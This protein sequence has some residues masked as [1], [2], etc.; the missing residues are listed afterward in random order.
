M[1]RYLFANTIGV[2]AVLL[3]M[4]WLQGGPA[5]AI[6][7]TPPADNAAPREGTGGASRSNFFVPPSD[8]TAPHRGTG[9]ASRGNFFVPPSD[10]AAPGESTGGA[11]RGGFFLPPSDNAAPGES[12]GGASRGEFFTPPSENGAPQESV[13]GGARSNSYGATHT[14]SQLTV[15]SMMAVTPE[16]FFGTTLEARPTILVYVPASNANEAIFTLKD[17]AKELVYQ[18]TLPIP[19]SGGV[20]SVEL[21]ADAPE[22]AVGQNY[23]WYLAMMLD[24]ELSPASPFV[25]GWVK[26]I[27]PSPELAAT[28]SQSEGLDDIA[29]LGAGGIWYDTVAQL[30]QLQAPQTDAAIAGHWQELLESVGLTDISTAP[31]VM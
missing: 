15:S 26:R 29:A 16:S 3:S 21:P 27:S 2:A 23:Q 7:F 25:D 10:N 20:V 14:T 22:L 17:E 13:G 8:N 12:T 5:Q 28:L 11:S 30:A 18:M 31:L 9:G 24:D 4:A 6:G 19:Q 1:K